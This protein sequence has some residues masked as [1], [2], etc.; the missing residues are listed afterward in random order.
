MK[1]LRLDQPAHACPPRLSRKRWCRRLRRCLIWGHRLLAEALCTSLWPVCPPALYRRCAATG[2]GHGRGANRPRPRPALNAWP[3]EPRPRGGRTPWLG[4]GRH[5]SRTHA[6]GH[7]GTGS[8]NPRTPWCRPSHCSGCTLHVKRL[9]DAPCF[10][11]CRGPVGARRAPAS[12]HAPSA[13]PEPLCASVQ[14]CG[15]PLVALRPRAATPPAQAA[16]SRGGRRRREHGRLRAER[17]R[18]EPHG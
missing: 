12:G 9:G 8:S 6:G 18:A 1:P 13:L 16:S 10:C 5:T 11:P 7:T 17:G 3:P 15:F 4:E 2:S 14:R